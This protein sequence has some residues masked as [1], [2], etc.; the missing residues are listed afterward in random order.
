MRTLFSLAI[1]ALFAVSL[2]AQTPVISNTSFNA[3]PRE[4][5]VMLTWTPESTGVTNYQLE[6]SRNGKDFEVFGTVQG[7]DMDIDFFETDFTPYLGVSYYRLKLISVDSVIT[8]S[9]IVPVS[10]AANG[11][12]ASTGSSQ[13]GFNGNTNEKSILVVVRSADGNEYYS[14][15]EIDSNGNPV[16]C[17]E[18]DPNLAAG[19]YTIIGCSEQ[20]LYARQLTVK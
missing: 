3:V 6:K 10:Y 15:I 2:Q 18:L 1:T 14:K 20:E 9:N 17:K 11:T 4:K 16:T 8:Y 19:N 5:Q 12:P 13:T 7:A